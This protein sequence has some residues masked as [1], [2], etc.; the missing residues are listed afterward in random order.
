MHGSL[1]GLA[2]IVTKAWPT[3]GSKNTY[4]NQMADSPIGFELA[5]DLDVFA[6]L[7]KR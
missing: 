5:A 2:F 7:R 6:M 4:S 3:N 1:T